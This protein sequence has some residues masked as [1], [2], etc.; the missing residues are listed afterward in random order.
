MSDP[1]DEGVTSPAPPSEDA[2][3]VG[4]GVLE[5]Q[6][7]PAPAK[8]VQ[9]V[10]RTRNIVSGVILAVVGLIAVFELTACLRFK[11]AFDR[12][13]ASL[14]ALENTSMPTSEMTY[15]DLEKANA[16]VGREPDGPLTAS[17][18]WQLATYSWRG[19]LRSYVIYARFFNG[20]PLRLHD[21]SANPEDGQ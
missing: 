8:P 16:L 18:E 9:G 21:V 19:V 15:P 17:N 20:T 13:N 3:G 12:L 7:A 10:S 5:P 6:T 4:T 2:V 11:F 14:S 1:I